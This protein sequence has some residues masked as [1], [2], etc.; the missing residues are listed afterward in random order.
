[1]RELSSPVTTKAEDVSSSPTAMSSQNETLKSSNGTGHRKRVF[2]FQKRWLHSL[3]IVERALFETETADEARDLDRLSSETLESN[4][5]DTTRQKDVIVCML[6][7]DPT[8]KRE[9]TKVWNRLNCRRGRIENHLVSKHPE[10]MRLLKHKREAEGDVAVQLFLQN[11]REGRCNARTEINNGLYSQL[12]LTATTHSTFDSE[13]AESNQKRAKLLESPV[14]T[15]DSALYFAAGLTVPRT[16]TTLSNTVATVDGKSSTCSTLYLDATIPPQWQTI[17]FNKLVV[18]TGGDNNN[19]AFI[20]TQLWLLGANVLL[21][22]CTVSALN[23]F[24]IKHN[25]RFPDPPEDEE[26]MRGV[27]LPVLVSFQT[28][29]SIDEWC[30]SIA[31]KYQRVDFLINYAGSEVIEALS[32][33]KDDHSTNDDP[34]C[35]FSSITLIEA[36]CASMSSYCFPDRTISDDTWST[37]STGTIVNVVSG[38]DDATVEPLVKMLAAKFQPRSV[39]VNC[40]L[41]PPPLEVDDAEVTDH[42]VTLSHT[43]LFL[44]SPLSRLLSGSVLRIQSGEIWLPST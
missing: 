28:Q 1:M 18:V 30:N 31:V 7:D 4:A 9:M 3:P 19:I 12:A 29:K 36:I 38:V 16:N 39:Q 10:F 15:K 32:S 25:G 5:T 6:C 2:T 20:A 14:D 22:F 21:A 26:N 37:T 13:D 42:T 24:N 43:I 27:M 17:F 33:E 11:L 23:E 34:K 8:S 35:I 40:V 44:L 41:L